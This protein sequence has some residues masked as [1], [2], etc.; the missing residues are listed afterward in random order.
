MRGPQVM[1]RMERSCSRRS[2]VVRTGE[3]WAM[4]GRVGKG[5]AADNGATVNGKGGADWPKPGRAVAAVAGR[6]QG[7]LCL[8]VAA[9]GRGRMARPNG[10]WLRKSRTHRRGDA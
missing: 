5:S 4:H 1:A 2:R 6:Q 3:G 7:A 10:T 9:Q 8:C